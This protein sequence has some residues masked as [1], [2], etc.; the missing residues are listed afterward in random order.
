[1][2]IVQGRHVNFHGIYWAHTTI[3]V[4]KMKFSPFIYTLFLHRF[5]PLFLKF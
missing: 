2:G 1:M 4:R 3:D 5:C